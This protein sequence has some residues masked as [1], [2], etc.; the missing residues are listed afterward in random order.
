V[1]GFQKEGKEQDEYV[2]KFCCSLMCHII[3]GISIRARKFCSSLNCLKDRSRDNEKH[4]SYLY[5]NR[6][7]FSVA[8][9]AVV[10]CRK[11]HVAFFF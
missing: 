10:P 9:S 6:P 2:S 7:S 5:L 8:K 1:F 3:F 4:L 11:F